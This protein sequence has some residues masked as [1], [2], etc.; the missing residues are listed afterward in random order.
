M[1]T[2]DF[3]LSENTHQMEKSGNVSHK[4]SLAKNLPLLTPPV[5]LSRAASFI[6]ACFMSRQ[7]FS[8]SR[9]FVIATTTA[10]LLRHRPHRTARAA[11][12]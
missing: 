11:H 5:L 9:T 2:A 8:P 1:K 12:G 10:T 3:S 6:F 4:S 7:F